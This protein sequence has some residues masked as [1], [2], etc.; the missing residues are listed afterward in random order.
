MRL[1]VLNPRREESL[2]GSG[3]QGLGV[4]RLNYN[5]FFKLSHRRTPVVHI[6]LLTKSP[7]RPSS[8]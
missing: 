6:T 2:G 5:P 8:V 4:C 7:D 1:C 3:V